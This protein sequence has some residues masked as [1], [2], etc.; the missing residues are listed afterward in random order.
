MEFLELLRAVAVLLVFVAGV[1]GV[2][3]PWLIRARSAR[4]L[5]IGNALA[6]GVMLAAGI[7]HLLSDAARDMDEEDPDGYPTAYLL[8]TVGF[9]VTMFMEE[10]GALL[11]RG[12]AAACSET[13]QSC[14]NVCKSVLSA[15]TTHTTASTTTQTTARTEE[16]GN[17]WM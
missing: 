6:G 5:A 9:V 3:L 17:L 14:A 4:M 12:A 11:M 10:I 2:A 16:V 15:Q 7:V 8:G 1:V 13:R